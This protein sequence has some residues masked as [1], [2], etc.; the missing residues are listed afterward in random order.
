MPPTSP[1]TPRDQYQ[2]YIPRFILRSFQDAQIHARSKKRRQKDYRKAKRTGVDQDMITVF[3]SKTQVLEQRPLA[4][5]YG[6]VNM[7]RD[8]RNPGN[9][10]HLEEALS[11]L[12]NSAAKLIKDMHSAV[13]EGKKIKMKRKELEVIRK[14]VYILHYR[15]VSLRPSYFDGND[16]DNASIKE[17]F[18][19]FRKKHNL[20]K[21]DDIWLW[22]LKYLL[23]T[24]HHKIVGMGAVIRERYGGLQQLFKMM[25][26]KVDPDLEN[27]HALDYTLIAG[28]S[29]LAIWEAAESEEFVV[30]S[31]SF[32]LFEGTAL[33]MYAHRIFVV[34][35]RIA[36]ILR[37]NALIPRMGALETVYN[38][39]LADIPTV[40]P[41][42][43][44][45]GFM[46]PPNASEDEEFAAFEA[47]R[48]TPIAQED[49]YTFTPSKLTPEQTHNVNFFILSH[50]DMGGVA[51]VSQKAMSRSLKHQIRADVS[52]IAESK[53]YLRAL[54]GVI[55]S[56]LAK[57]EN[58]GSSP[59]R[60][61][62]DVIIQSSASG[63]IE[64]NSDYDRA[65]R[66]Y[67]SATNDVENY[68]QTSADIHAITARAIVKMKTLL[69]PPP[70]IN[71][72]MHFPFL[73]RKIVK[74]LP[75]ADSE[76][77]FALVGYQ[78]DV[79]EVGTGGTDVVGQIKYE[80]AII[81][82]AHWLA[83]NRPSFLQ[84]LTPRPLVFMQ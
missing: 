46:P 71:R 49:R 77:F 34:S 32:G 61:V 42:S 7:Y 24:P 52:Y 80:A 57:E 68:C 2:H 20:T 78:V 35:P 25:A 74:T 58:E 21:P 60:P 45:V 16:P 64:S 6:V 82:F 40:P 70:V 29:F 36:L 10:N 3:D 31:N 79:L 43:E 54:L 81:G 72:H 17:F 4:K 84:E 75:K 19:S 28:S 11:K 66:I 69:P 76:L 65:Y 37:H 62:L 14:F 47:Y 1:S 44:R 30:G 9:M 83:E 59:P 26:T 48:Q 51:F 8:Q 12:E 55:A 15:R 13:A 50:L 41:E 67:H 18:E 33:G 22:G 56:N 5:E 39:I 23:D 27:Y 63:A 53:Y 73:S 38:S